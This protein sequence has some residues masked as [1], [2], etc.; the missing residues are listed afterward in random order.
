M[1][2]FPASFPF[3][4]NSVNR[5]PYSGHLHVFLDAIKCSIAVSYHSS[6]TTNTIGKTSTASGQDK[7]GASS[8]A[9]KTHEI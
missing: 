1:Q 5:P 7:V 6:T 8:A 4:T 3:S 9:K 2:A